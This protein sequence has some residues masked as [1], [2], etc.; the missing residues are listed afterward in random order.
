MDYQSFTEH[1]RALCRTLVMATG[2]LGGLAGCQTNTASPVW[3]AVHPFQA[4]ASDQANCCPPCAAYQTTVW[5]PWQSGP[6]AIRCEAS[7]PPTDGCPDWLN[8]GATPGPASG[9]L[10][11]PEAIPTPNGSP[12]TN[13][14]PPLGA[15]F[16][17]VPQDI[18]P[19]SGNESRDQAVRDLE[20]SR[21]MYWLGKT[22][23]G[24]VAI[25]PNAT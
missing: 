19:G 15:A 24:A 12:N 11:R 7:A 5:E 9:T 22:D 8:N 14:K 23:S 21:R 6:M 1:S 3:R 16:M 18:T 2:L 25:P 4:D 17:H 13:V 10:P 20:A